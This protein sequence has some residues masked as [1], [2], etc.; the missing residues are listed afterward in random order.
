MPL[1]PSWHIGMI[2]VISGIVSHPDSLHDSPRSPVVRD[3]ERDDFLQPQLFESKCNDASRGLGG[4]TIAPPI[5][6]Q[7]P[8]H[9]HARCEV[10]VKSWDGEADETGEG[11]ETDNFQSPRSESVIMEVTLDPVYQ[12]IAL[13]RSERGR[14][15]FHHSRIG[16][17]SGKWISI[18]GDP[19]PQEQPV[20]R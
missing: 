4:V 19:S 10:S 3:S 17:D 14:K 8:T 6:G 20:G 1:E 13:F 18:R 9:F 7:A 11:Y 2:E 12:R 15:V 16:I 5:G